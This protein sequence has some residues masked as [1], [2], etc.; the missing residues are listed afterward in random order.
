MSHSKR[1]PPSGSIKWIN[2]PGQPN[3]VM[4]LKDEPTVY[5]AEGSVAHELVAIC[6]EKN[7]KAIEYLD[8]YGYH[9]SGGQT[10]IVADEKHIP[11]NTF[12]STQI[13]AETVTHCQLYIDTCW[14][15]VGPLDEIQI[16]KKMDMGWVIPGMFG[17]GDFI[18]MSFGD[19]VTVVDLKYGKSYVEVNHNT[20][21]MIYGLGAIGA[22]DNPNKF[23]WVKLVCIQPREGG[24][25]NQLVRT[26]TYSADHLLKWGA[27]TLVPAA[28]ANDDPGAPRI[29]GDW[30][31]HWC[32]AAKQGACPEYMASKTQAAATALFGTRQQ[33]VVSPAVMST[34][35]TPPA[36]ATLT[37]DDLDFKLGMIDQ[38]KE[39][40]KMLETE[41]KRRLDIGDP[42]APTTLKL[43]AGKK[44]ARKWK[45]PAQALA[46][47]QPKL[48]SRITTKP[49]I[50]TV[51]QV[52]NE[53]KALGY[54]PAQVKA[55]FGD[56][57]A[58][59]SEGKPMMVSINNKKPALP[60][61]SERL[62]NAKGAK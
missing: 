2:C 21:F 46:T 33:P 24:V 8:W 26:V 9:H 51:T 60:P 25:D 13:S 20:Q 49:G 4:N 12:Y 56:L 44:G 30:C 57:V 14:S 54:K 6:L 7:Q 23:K 45:N 29:V 28:R 42:Q 62:F 10:G 38:V 50:K 15:L 52:E 31:N 3:A 36:P 35:K 16:E 39:Y 5:S 40:I 11:G 59:P 32:L 58:P 48:G 1:H 19:T 27:E 41:A 37:A 34:A 55:V 18:T 22:W 61:K 43:V 53:M 47:L 17:T